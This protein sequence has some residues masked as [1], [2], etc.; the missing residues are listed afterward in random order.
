MWP[1]YGNP[2]EEVQAIRPELDQVFCDQG[3]T[4]T[5]AIRESWMTIALAGPGSLAESA[6]AVESAASRLSLYCQVHRNLVII[7]TAATGT[8]ATHANTLNVYR[9]ARSVLLDLN[10]RLSEFTRLAQAV[11][12]DDGTG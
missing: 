6:E 3:K 12:D 7:H 8:D 2:P 5:V 11:L 1:M 10:K 4:F 9:E